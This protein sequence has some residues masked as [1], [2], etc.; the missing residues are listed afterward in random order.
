MASLVFWHCWAQNGVL[1]APMLPVSTYE[2]GVLGETLTAQNSVS[3]AGLC[4]W[5]REA[6]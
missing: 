6:P 5:D 1:Q 3:R 2:W 4:H